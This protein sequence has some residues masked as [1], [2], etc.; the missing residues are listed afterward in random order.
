MSDCEMVAFV[1]RMVFGGEWTF[2]VVE[3]KSPGPERFDVVNHPRGSMGTETE[4]K[5]S[6]YRETTSCAS[7]R[8]AMRSQTVRSFFMMRQGVAGFSA[9]C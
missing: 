2:D 9:G 3:M 7:A 8:D 4:S 1:E 6:T 5:V